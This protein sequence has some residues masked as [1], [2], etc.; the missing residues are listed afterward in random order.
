MILEFFTQKIQGTVNNYLLIAL[1]DI[2]QIPSTI[3]SSYPG[4]VCLLTLALLQIP[5]NTKCDLLQIPPNTKCDTVAY[6]TE[7]DYY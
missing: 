7:F 3:S 4:F 5:P 1:V 2:G 6:R